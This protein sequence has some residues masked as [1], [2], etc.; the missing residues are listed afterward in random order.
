EVEERTSPEIAL[1]LAEGRADLGI[2]DVSTPSAGLEFLPFF[3]DRL[4]LI[5]PRGHALEDAQQVRLTDLMQQRFIVQAGAAALNTRLFN[6]AAALGENIQVR[7]QMRSFD[8]AC[9]MV[10]AGLGVAVLPQEAI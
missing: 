5:V 6:A 1:A 10:A 8:A 4:A 2:V 7:M 3:Q 9:R